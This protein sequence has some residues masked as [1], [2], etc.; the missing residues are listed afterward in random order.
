M[1]FSPKRIVDG[2]VAASFRQVRRSKGAPGVDEVSLA[3][4]EED[5]GN[6]LY[7]IWIRPDASGAAS[8][9]G[10]CATGAPSRWS[11]SDAVGAGPPVAG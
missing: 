8:D 9:I 1:R 10:S 3:E 5:L 2:V 11:S 4:F 7:K 6:T